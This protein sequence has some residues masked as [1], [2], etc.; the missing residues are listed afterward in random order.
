MAA[1]H[2]LIL[3]FILLVLASPFILVVW[4]VLRRPKARSK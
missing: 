3:A 4:L 1:L 2:W